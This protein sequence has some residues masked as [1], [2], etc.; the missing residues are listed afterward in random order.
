MLSLIGTDGTNGLYYNMC[1]YWNDS[2]YR[3]T[4]TDYRAVRK[5]KV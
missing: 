2:G 4:A 3:H 5:P 1:K